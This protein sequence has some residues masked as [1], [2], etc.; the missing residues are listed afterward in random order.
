M[1]FGLGG[2]TAR[3]VEAVDVG[4]TKVGKP[5]GDRLKAGDLRPCEIAILGAVA[6][7][8]AQMGE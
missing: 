6:V 2:N 1:I 7:R 8:H 4:K 3:R 5:I